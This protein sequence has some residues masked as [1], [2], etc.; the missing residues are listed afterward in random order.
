MIHSIFLPKPN[1]GKS[2]LTNYLASNQI[3]R[4]SIAQQ[5]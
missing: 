1:R 2:T 3:V 5:I 4:N